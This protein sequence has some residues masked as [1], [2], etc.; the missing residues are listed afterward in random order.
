MRGLGHLSR[1]GV[2]QIGDKL[3]LTRSLDRG[4]PRAHQLLQLILGHRDAVGRDDLGLPPL[5]EALVLNFEDRHLGDTGVQ[6]EH[7]LNLRRKM[8]SPPDTIISSSRP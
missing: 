5:A 2:R 3:D 4:K 7:V 8:F 6:G 1:F